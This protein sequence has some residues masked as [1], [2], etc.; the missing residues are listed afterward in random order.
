MWVNIGC[1][2]LLILIGAEGFHAIDA[3]LLCFN[4]LA[5]MNICFF[6]FTGWSREEDWSAYSAGSENSRY[7]N[8]SLFLTD[9][10]L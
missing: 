2:I 9:N 3:A 5:F 10:E 1:V 8:T 4:D 6:W 7:R